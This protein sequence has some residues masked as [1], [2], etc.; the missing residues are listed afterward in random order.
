MKNQ[1]FYYMTLVLALVLSEPMNAQLD[2]A[3]SGDV[4]RSCSLKRNL[5]NGDYRPLLENISWIS[6][7]FHICPPLK[8]HVFTSIG[9]TILNDL[10][11]KIIRKQVIDL[12]DNTLEGTENLYF[13]ED[14]NN[15]HVYK[16]LTNS[17]TDELLYDF[18][19]QVGDVMPNFNY[20]VLKEISVID[21][22]G[23]ARRTFSFEYTLSDST[24][25]PFTWIEGIGSCSSLDMPTSPTGEYTWLLCV[26]NDEQATFEYVDEGSKYS[27]QY[28]QNIIDSLTQGNENISIDNSTAVKILRDNQVLILRGEKTYTVTGQEVK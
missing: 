11:H 21:Y 16:Y 26:H 8:T 18:S 9:D 12:R 5:S 10:P 27:C 28:V 14:V 7:Y 1:I 6:L 19:L 22:L 13:Y 17:N 23:T 15:R 4:N 2:V 25:V 20:A 24:R 3:T